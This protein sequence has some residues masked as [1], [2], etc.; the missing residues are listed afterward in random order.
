VGSSYYDGRGVLTPWSKG[1]RDQTRVPRRDLATCCVAMSPP[2]SA[3]GATLPLPSKI[4]HFL[5]YFPPTPPPPFFS[6]PPPPFSPIFFSLPPPPCT[7]PHPHSQG[8][9]FSPPPHFGVARPRRVPLPFY[10]GFFAPPGHPTINSLN[11]SHD[12]RKSPSS[13]PMMAAR[14]ATSSCQH[15]IVLKRRRDGASTRIELAKRPRSS[16]AW[17]V[18]VAHV[19]RALRGS[20]IDHAP[21]PNRW[22]S[23][24]S[25]R[26]ECK[27]ADVAAIDHRPSP[28]TVLGR[29]RRRHGADRAESRP[30]AQ[31]L[32]DG[33]PHSLFERGS[34]R[35]SPA[36][37]P[38]RD[39]SPRDQSARSTSRRPSR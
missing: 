1:E 31:E 8:W 28:R 23:T 7:P 19:S 26:L 4:F 33:D 32:L 25:R 13:R 5:A 39:R 27:A 9:F 18:A 6:P 15:V 24:G 30:R 11:V 21:R 16:S 3:G 17:T 14:W 12:H 37:Q 20:R 22:S 35:W 2:E 36:S 29:R 38:R 34:S 10:S